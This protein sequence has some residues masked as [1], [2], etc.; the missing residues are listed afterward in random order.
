MSEVWE[1]EDE[2]S[3]DEK[4]FLD[5][6]S[7]SGAEYTSLQMLLAA[8]GLHDWTQFAR[9]NID[10]EA[11]LVL[12]EN[13]FGDVLGTPLGPRKKLLKAISERRRDMEEPEDISN[14]RL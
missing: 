1:D 6:D 13:D 12:N 3:G 4:T 8:V 14:C 7:G 9:E 2:L 10:L 11:L 5:S